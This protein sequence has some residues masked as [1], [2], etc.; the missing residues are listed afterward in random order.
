MR[1]PFTKD[2][3][4]Y[5][6]LFFLAVP[7][8][9][10]NL[11]S[12]LV[13][14]ADNLMVG[15]LGNEAV[16]GVYM[17]S[18]LQTLLGMLSF[19][20]SGT[21]AIIGAQYWGKR[22]TLSMR[23]LVAIGMRL[24]VAVGAVFT[25][26]GFLFPE[27]IVRIFTQ[28]EGVVREGAIYLKYVSFSFFFFCA[29]QPL[30]AAMRSVE[31]TNTGMIVSLTSLIVNVGLNYVLIYGK[32]GFPA[33][34][35][36]GAA[37]AT[38]YS[39][40]AETICI[41]CI[42]LKMDKRLCLT[43]SDFLLRDTALLRDFVRYGAPLVAGEI[44]WSVNMMAN[45]AIIGQ[46]D[47]AVITAV[48]VANTMNTLAYVTI[49]GMA[50]AVGIITGKTIGAGKTGLMKEY[51]YTTQAIFLILGAVMGTFVALMNAPFVSLYENITPA[52]AEQARQFIRVLSVTI[53]GTCYQMPCLFGLVKSGGD[54]SFVFKNDSIFVFLVVLP[55]AFIA[56]RLGAAPWVVFFCLKCD[57]ILKCF[58]AVVKVNR[59]DWMKNLTR[60]AAAEAS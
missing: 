17:G 48:S 42:A 45:S 54:I 53:I 20:V 50:T 10:Q 26:A 60:G 22:D 46:Y 30:I 24:S 37:I 21:I 13:T 16:S 23:K 36:K 40:V 33:M 35:V 2:R 56:S 11:I 14:F 7:V 34:G 18:Q 4:Y 8:A 55:S 41:L 59:F 31:R 3:A 47:A 32:L 43:P 27:P 58:V 57:Q 49:G 6:D 1:N 39:R 51:A 29:T 9:L 38:V 5:R 28:E 12:F 25:L 19:G 52:A 44:V 15:S